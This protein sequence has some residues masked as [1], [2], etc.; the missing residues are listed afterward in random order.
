MIPVML[1]VFLDELVQASGERQHHLVQ[2]LQDIATRH[3]RQT[4]SIIVSDNNIVD[5]PNI[6]SDTFKSIMRP[7]SFETGMILRQIFESKEWDLIYF[8]GNNGDKINYLSDKKHEN[9]IITSFYRE[10][11]DVLKDIA[12]QI[13]RL[14]RTRDLN[15]R[16]KFV[17]ASVHVKGNINEFAPDLFAELWKWKILNAILVAPTSQNNNT[18]EPG[19]IPVLDIYTWFPYHPPG[20]C[21]DVRDAVLLDRWVSKEKRQ[22]R[23]LNN[24]PLFP[25][26]IPENFHGCQLRVS[27]FEYMPFIGRKKTT[28]SDPIKIIFDEGLEVR[29]L[30]HISEKKNLSIRF[31][32]LPADGG[33]W[34]VNLGNGTWTGVAGEIIRSYSDIA[35]GNWWYR[36]HLI[37]DVECL[38]PHSIDQVRWYVP[39]AKPYP[40]WMSI[41]RVF[42]LS[43]W[44]GFLSSYTVVSISMW[45]IV[46]LSN[47]ISKKPIENQAYTSLVKCLLNFWAIILEESASNNPPH[48]AV[49]RLVFFM[50]V[51]YCWAVNTVYQT[52]M[53][54]FLIDPGLQHQ[55]SS[56]AEL[57][58]SGMTLGIPATV[59]S[60]IPDISDERY[61]RHDSCIDVTSCEDRMAFKGDMA[62]F[63]SKYNMEYFA[64]VKYVDGEGET[65][66]CKFDEICCIQLGTFPVPR[67][68]Q[69]LEI[70]NK[71]IIRL[72]QGGFKEQWWKEIQFAATL[73]LASD[74]NLP[75]GEYIKL[76]LEHLQSAFYFLFL[77]YI[78][79]IVAFVSELSYCRK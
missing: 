11:P 18:V 21:T 19:L 63:F 23:F 60:V 59:L 24:V 36:C 27:T 2:C 66:V 64:A 17:I 57:L 47:S 38:I 65:L 34:G 31:L 35:T 73:D 5:K 71:I 54:S 33:K 78:L 41:T 1:C 7:P 51:L 6:K 22:G 42:K 32:D 39:C 75:P 79:S 49:I 61:R 28:E 13:S 44:L 30:K 68:S 46:K 50:W 25:P 76:T 10:H 45:L 37:E 9:Y 26:K 12:Q 70:F 4:S 67:G 58:T 72:L 15:P 74:F 77:G 14:R 52:F 55:I 3:F 43:L 56:E 69:F 16:A 8:H 48:V 20:H 62:F 53:T 29:L 40:R